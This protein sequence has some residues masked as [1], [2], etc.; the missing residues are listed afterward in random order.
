MLLLLLLCCCFEIWQENGDG[1]ARI[2]FAIGL[3]RIFRDDDPSPSPPSS[4]S[5]S[6]SLLWG[7][8]GGGSRGGV[9]SDCRRRK[10]DLVQRI[11]VNQGKPLASSYSSWFSALTLLMFDAYFVGGEWQLCPTQSIRSNNDT[12]LCRWNQFRVLF[13]WLKRKNMTADGKKLSRKMA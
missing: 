3:P 5:S 8:R 12:L 6:S 10:M 4:S 7:G 9:S 13:I 1:S 11:N 2:I